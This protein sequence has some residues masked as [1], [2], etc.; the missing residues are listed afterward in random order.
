MKSKDRVVVKCKVG[1]GPEILLCSLIPG[2][3]ESS[4]LDLLF[5]QDVVFSVTGSTSVHLTGYYMPIDDTE[6][7]EDFDS[8]PSCVCGLLTPSFREV[9]V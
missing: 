1:E 5:D 2:V 9:R 6:S 3:V 7:D 4:N 8:Y